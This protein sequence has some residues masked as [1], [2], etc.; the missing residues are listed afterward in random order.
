MTNRKKI[1]NHDD[2][3]LIFTA[4]SGLNQSN[5]FPWWSG[6]SGW[7]VGGPAWVPGRVLSCFRSRPWFQGGVRSLGRGGPVYFLFEKFEWGLG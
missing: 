2:F 5:L 7:W 1:T 3:D 6:C 4:L